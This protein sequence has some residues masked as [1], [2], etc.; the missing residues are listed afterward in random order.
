MG[1]AREE[2]YFTVE[3]QRRI[4]DDALLLYTGG[5]HLPCVILVDGELVGR[6]NVNNIV[7][8]ACTPVTSAT[9]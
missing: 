3:G 4:V 9:G 7:R 6:I 2:E 8:G 1:A 5:I